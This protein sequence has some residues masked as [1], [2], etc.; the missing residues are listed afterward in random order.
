MP[1]WG[2]GTATREFLYAA[3]CADAIVRATRHYDRPE[4][5]NLGS[6]Q[7]I[8]VHDLANLIAPAERIYRTTRLGHHHKPDGQPRRRLD[9][10]RAAD[11][12]GWTAS[13][14]LETG[15]RETI[16]FYRANRSAPPERQFPPDA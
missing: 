11:W 15:L 6:G 14:P 10:T 5:I 12:L 16:A 9:V 4:P 13:T 8:A 2:S 7:E 3:D 1:V